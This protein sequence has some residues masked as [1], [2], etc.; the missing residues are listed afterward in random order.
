MSF[1]GASGSSGGSGH[2]PSG[3][4]TSITWNRVST[5]NNGTPR[6]VATD[7]SGAT[8]PPK[9]RTGS[10]VSSVIAK[11]YKTSDNSLVETIN[12]FNFNTNFGTSLVKGTSYYLKLTIVDSVTGQPGDEGSK[13]SD[14]VGMVLP[15]AQT[16]P[17]AVGSTEY[18]SF[19][20]TA[21]D[22]GGGS[23]TYRT[24]L[25]QS[26]NSGS[27]Y[28]EYNTNPSQ[29]ATSAAFSVPGGSTYRYKLNVLPSNELGSSTSADSNVVTVTASAPPPPPPP[30]FPGFG[31]FFPGFGPSFGGGGGP[32]SLYSNT[33]VRTPNGLVLA[34]Q[35][36]VGDQLTSVVLPGL[37]E[38]GW[39][40]QDVIDWYVEN[41]NF[42]LSN[43]VTT[44]IVD[45]VHST[46]DK[47][48][49][50]NGDAFSG[51]HRIMV[52]RDNVARMISA[53]DIVDTDLI[54]SPT[55]ITWVPITSIESYDST[56]D[57]YS[58]N[59]EPYDIFF[60]ENMLVHDTRPNIPS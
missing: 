40:P 22:A 59:C 29:T 21:P 19:T 39:T 17:T 41:P 9:R 5:A 42:D 14:L 15:G 24:I 10:E 7:Y 23:L 16:A 27:N 60:T 20:W 58:V 11:L 3:G 13:S 34:S 31:P 44:T 32:K 18:V 50:I 57:I 45:I 30:F 49:F 38:D 2:L 12:N 35:L 55:D 53:L 28:I 4:P 26:T 25:Y 33:K 36:Q 54:W 47:I 51:S 48:F 37:P 1:L 46:T 8:Y 52:N 6:F 56:H 43:T